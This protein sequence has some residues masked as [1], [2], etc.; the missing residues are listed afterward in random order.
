MPN[1]DV[2]AIA[3]EFM[4]RAQNEGRG[5]TNM[6]LQKL[7]YIAHGW[8]LVSFPQPLIGQQPYTWPYGPVYPDLYQD[9]K[10]YGSGTVDSFIRANNSSPFPEDRGAEVWSA[11]TPNE[12]ALLDQVWRTYGSLDGLQL[13]EITHRQGTPWTTI[14]QH[15][16]AFSPIDNATIQ[17]HYQAL[18]QQNELRY[19]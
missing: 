12:A 4:R 18:R 10:R 8:G 16:G 9:L 7:P 17:Q 15:Y 14:M 5:L 13:S 1:H 3:N 19:Q 11:I 6:Q 2:R